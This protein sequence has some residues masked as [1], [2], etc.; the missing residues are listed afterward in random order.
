MRTKLGLVW[1]CVRFWKLSK[2]R[3]PANPQNGPVGGVWASCER[4]QDSGET[5]WEKDNPSTQARGRAGK[6]KAEKEKSGSGGPAK[7]AHITPTLS[8]KTEV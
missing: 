8:S 1:P 3:I 2:E 5:G 4:N 6:R 7:A